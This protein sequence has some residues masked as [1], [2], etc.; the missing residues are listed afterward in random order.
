M[1]KSRAAS[2]ASSAN[3]SFLGFWRCRSRAH[4][5]FLCRS[6]RPVWHRLEAVA[7]M[8][9]DTFGVDFTNAPI[10]KE[11]LGDIE[12]RHDIIH[13]SGKNKSGV[14]HMLVDEDIH[15]GDSAVR[16]IGTRNRA[17]AG[18]FHSG[19]LEFA[20]SPAN[21]AIHPAFPLTIPLRYV[22]IPSRGLIAARQVTKGN[23]PPMLAAF[24]FLCALGILI[25]FLW[26]IRT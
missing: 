19:G 20:R 7:K 24:R 10:V 8:F 3:T 13:R 17:A 26:E 9:S 25:E 6:R 23:R 4:R 15:K 2:S 14:E 5:S 18:Q 22:P 16:G 21:T 11:L 12:I 1:S